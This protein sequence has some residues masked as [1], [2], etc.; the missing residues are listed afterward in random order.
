MNPKLIS[1][2]ITCPDEDEAA[3]LSM[4]LLEEELVAC[5]S[6]FPVDSS[7]WWQGRLETEGEYAILAKSIDSNWKAIV[8]FVE[9]KHSYDVPCIIRYPVRANKAYRDWVLENVGLELDEQ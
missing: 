7:Y 4:A 3:G 1:I 6:V 9:S 8:E 5:A 2:Y